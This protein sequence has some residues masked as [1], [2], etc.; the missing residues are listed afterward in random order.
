MLPTF[1]L[2]GVAGRGTE[3]TTTLCGDSVGRVT[4]LARPV[5]VACQDS[6]LVGG[7]WLEGL[8]NE[9]GLG[10]LDDGLPV[11]EPPLQHLHL[12]GGRVIVSS[13]LS[14]HGE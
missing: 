4:R 14:H 9:G 2:P 5:L 8:H 11:F 7:G 6:E 13:L 1:F 10:L 12:S 3:P